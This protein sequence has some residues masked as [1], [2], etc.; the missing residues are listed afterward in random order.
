MTVTKKKE[1]FF[2]KTE[3]HSQGRFFVHLWSKKFLKFPTLPGYRKEHLSAIIQN[4]KEQVEI[5]HKF[6]T[7]KYA[8]KEFAF[9]DQV[10]G[11]DCLYIGANFR[12]QSTIFWGK[13]DAAFSNQENILLSVRVADCIPV[14][15]YSENPFFF[16]VIHAGWKGLYGNI[17]KKTLNK[18]QT[19]QS[20]EDHSSTKFW[21]G[22][23]I[24]QDSYVVG[25]DVF[26][27]F[28]PKHSKDTHQKGKKL[29]NLGG[30][31]REQLVAFEINDSQIYW[32]K[33]DTFT[34]EDLYSHRKGDIGRNIVCISSRE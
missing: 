5:L 28:H 32:Q 8:N 34:D 25:K 7:K 15:F 19:K 4:K 16:G 2:S 20:L 13:G 18:V 22:P 3:E 14:A 33:K 11:L 9:L 27:L 6:F 24:H 10:H 21:I 12:R 31:L 23:Y 1:E 26:T 30:I 29:L 17:V